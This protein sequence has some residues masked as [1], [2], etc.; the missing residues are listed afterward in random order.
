MG[1]T[2]EG[3]DLVHGTSVRGTKIEDRSELFR[4][5]HKWRCPL[6]ARYH[7][8]LRCMGEYRVQ[9]WRMR[10]QVAGSLS[11]EADKQ[12][13]FFKAFITYLRRGHLLGLPGLFCT[14]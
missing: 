11:E 14:I 2:Y 5:K 6:Q 8:I 4:Q 3:L 9:S 10:H 13:K 1:N 7:D 12:D